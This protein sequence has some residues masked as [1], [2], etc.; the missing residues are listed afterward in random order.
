[1]SLSLL[2]RAMGWAVV[3][4]LLAGL[5]PAFA[6]TGGL[7]GV[8]KGEKG[9]VLVGYPII[10]E[11]QD[12]KGLYKTKTNKKGEYIYIGLPIGNY[13]VTIQD[14]G[15]R[16]LFYMTTRV[17]LGDPTQLDFDLGKER[18]RAAEDRQKQIEANPELKK[19]QEQQE[20]ETKQFTGLKQ[21]FDQGQLLM[22]EKRYVEAAGMF[23]Q[24]LPLAKDKN[25]PVLLSRLGDAYARAARVEGNRDTRIQHEEKSLDYY[26][27]AIQ[28]DPNNA[29]LHEA[30]G[31]LYSDTGKTEEAQ[32]EYQ[33]AIEL[34]P[35]GAA[36][37]YYN[38]G[39]VFV[40]KGKMDEAAAALK[41]CTEL[42]PT[43]ANAFY[44]YATALLGK[45]E[46][47]PDGTM[48]PV[49]G[50]I[51]AFET[52]LKLAPDGQWATSAKASIEQLQ[53]KVQMEY[54]AQKKKKG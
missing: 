3:F 45:V 25:V 31:S 19:Q 17:G 52:Y 8:A 34:N 53:G 38:M 20:R 47:K 27:K 9:E 24:A 21:M 12:V 13:K 40:N 14:M 36:S 48:V 26:T 7:T 51:E 15:G 37:Y 2:R 54:K 39:V 44:W 49:P 43:N 46:Y 32:Q 41:K 18:A 33:K 42:D 5:V 29:N 50:T 1:M 16:D 6:Q 28:A 10:I 22:Q 4:G 11:R 23:E 30:L 35:T